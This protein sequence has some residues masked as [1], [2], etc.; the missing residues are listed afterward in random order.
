MI[1]KLLTVVVLLYSLNTSANVVPATGKVTDLYFYGNGM[2][3]VQ[4]FDFGATDCAGSKFGFVIAPDYVHMDKILSILL[5]AKVTQ[6]DLI[7][8]ATVP[9]IDCWAPTF[10]TDNYLILK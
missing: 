9:V 5:T 3:L 4:G 6:K 10:T 2:I 8:Y 7:V 1:K